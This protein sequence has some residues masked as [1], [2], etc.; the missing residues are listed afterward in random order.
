MRISHSYFT[1]CMIEMFQTRIIQLT[2]W[3]CI[4]LELGETV[5]S[6]SFQK[7]IMW[8]VGHSRCINHSIHR[9]YAVLG[10]LSVKIR[11]FCFQG[12][13]KLKDHQCS[14]WTN[15]ELLP[16]VSER[17]ESEVIANLKAHIAKLQQELKLKNEKLVVSWFTYKS[18]TA[19]L[20]NSQVI[21]F[22]YFI[23]C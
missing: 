13:R 15:S 4:Y 17:E 12:E 14:E 7:Q 6:V 11:V 3:N 22:K 8:I 16:L 5:K 19:V 1:A 10:M 21:T 20:N 18:G 9:V 23:C 2:K